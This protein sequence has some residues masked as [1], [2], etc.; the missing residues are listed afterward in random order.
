MPQ[1]RDAGARRNRG[2]GYRR[3][4]CSGPIVPGSQRPAK[5]SVSSIP[6]RPSMPGSWRSRSP[7][8]IQRRMVFSNGRWSKA[9]AINCVPRWCGSN[10]AKRRSETFATATP[11][12]NWRSN[13]KGDSLPTRSRTTSCSSNRP[14]AEGVVVVRQIWITRAGP[15]EVLQVKEAADPAPN[16]G[17]VRIRVEASGV[18]FADIMG[19]MGVYPDLPPIPV[20]PGYE[21]SGRIDAVASGVDQSWIGQDVIALTRFGGYA[22]VICVPLKQIFPRPAGLS[23]LDGAAIPVNCFTAWQLVVVMGALKANEIVLIHSV[24]GVGIAAT[25]ADAESGGRGVFPWAY[26]D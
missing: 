25:R 1:N 8:S 2:A 12:S 14:S 6:G 26:P 5:L 21:V 11:I 13:A 7:T 23:A 10:Y 3:S 17:E 18:N 15:P 16:A 22:D 4:K 19:R 20:V 24:G 9:R